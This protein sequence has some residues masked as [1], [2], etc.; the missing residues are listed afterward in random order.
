MAA[1][2]FRADVPRIRQE[3]SC[4]F[5]SVV[6][7]INQHGI[8]FRVG[9]SR[10]RTAVQ[11]GAPPRYR[12]CLRSIGLRRQTV[13]PTVRFSATTV[14]FTA[15]LSRSRSQ[16]R[17]RLSVVTEQQ[18]IARD[19]AQKPSY[20]PRHSKARRGEIPGLLESDPPTVDRQE[21]R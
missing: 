20:S 13:L 16:Q 4:N 7:N 3:A 21:D 12:S 6:N 1:W 5:L 15:A 10:G 8:V 9:H 2:S 14:E 19:C 17:A 11:R 18:I